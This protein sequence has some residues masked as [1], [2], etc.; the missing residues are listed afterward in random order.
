MS[1]NN[2]YL[3]TSESDANKA[4][5][6]LDRIKISIEKISENNTNNSPS[7]KDVEED[8]N[9][10]SEFFSDIGSGISYGWDVASGFVVDKAVWVADKTVGLHN[11]VVDTL[12]KDRTFKETMDFGLAL[13]QRMGQYF[14]SDV[15]K[16][17]TESFSSTPKWV[18]SLPENSEDRQITDYVGFVL[19]HASAGTFSGL[20]VAGDMLVK[21]SDMVADAVNS[22]ADFIGEKAASM[23]EYIPSDSALGAAIRSVLGAVKDSLGKY[24][25]GI[26]ETTFG[27]HM[28]DSWHGS[29]K[30]FLSYIA[31]GSGNKKFKIM[32]SSPLDGGGDIKNLYGSMMLG[33]PYL[34]TTTTDPRRRA[35]INTFIKDGRFI[36]LTPG[37]PKYYGTSYMQTAANNINK[38]TETPTE[39]INYLMK[40][41]IDTS[42]QHKDKRYY[43]FDP[44]YESYYAYL[45][46]MLNSIWIKMG[47]SNSSEN[48][49][50]IFSFF[51]TVG[52][53]GNIKPS[54]QGTLQSRY[55][56][57][58]GFYCNAAGV[59][60]ESVSNSPTSIGGSMAGNINNQSDEFQKINYVTGMGTGGVLKTASRNIAMGMAVGNNM[61]DK[62]SS[63]FVKAKTFAKKGTGIRK[64]FYG[65]IGA[66]LDVARINANEDFGTWIQEFSTTNGMKVVY[67]ELWSDSS[68]SK[69]FSVSFSFTSP[70]GDPASIFKYVYVPFC[71]LLCFALPRQAAENGMVSPFFVRADIP[72]VTTSDLAFISDISWT[73]GG[74]NNL[75]TKDGLPRSIDVQIT[76]NDLYPYLAMTKRLSFLSANPSYTVFLDNM[77]GLC[78]VYDTSA[79]TDPLNNYWHT[80][81]NRVSGKQSFGDKLWNK[82]NTDKMTANIYSAINS[83]RRSVTQNTDY[84]QIPWLH[85][86][87]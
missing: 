73:K 25:D 32:K 60:S 23:A 9:V 64:G 67:P 18:S 50:N 12:W 76:I 41:G 20:K 62:I 63:G 38:Q 49:F 52:D 61:L 53:D 8:K 6:E 29:S 15:P 44:K 84:S 54:G 34:N 21:G 27:S 26:S 46:T 48:E 14:S 86:A 81:I 17:Y 33:C 10:V 85:K 58:I 11:N 35:A 82:F 51:E 4:L 78:S 59:V 66:G 80:L 57:S 37:L 3:T 39:M 24:E 13:F 28:E 47:L 5:E 70:Y 2:K 71:A 79:N 75:W 43:I 55:K 77:S 7:D 72:G 56:S 83:E 65:L 36:S 74:S 68:Y 16:I 31:S 45:E 30:S 42:F 22:A 1:E 69:S 40:N 19:G 87:D